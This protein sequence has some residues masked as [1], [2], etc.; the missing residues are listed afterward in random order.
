MTGDTRTQA[1]QLADLTA[2]V[3]EL[4]DSQAAMVAI[5]TKLDTTWNQATGTL[6]VIKWLAIVSAAC[7]TAW[8]GLKNHIP[9]G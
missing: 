5:V 4:N 6:N 7:A 3:S 2:K 1:A 8:A 9:H